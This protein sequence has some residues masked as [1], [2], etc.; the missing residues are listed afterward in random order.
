MFVTGLNLRSAEKI[1]GV[2][3]QMIRRLDENTVNRIAAGEVIHSPSNA[4]KELLENSIDAKAT[5]IST[6]RKNSS[7]ISLEIT[8]TGGGIKSMHIQDNGQGIKV[9]VPIAG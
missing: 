2:K 7:N 5:S 9:S 4:I 6:R 3:C 8:I 1:A